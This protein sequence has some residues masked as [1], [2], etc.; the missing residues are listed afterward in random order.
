[1]NNE[2]VLPI[3]MREALKYEEET[4]GA[5]CTIINGAFTTGDLA[6]EAYCAGRAAPVTELEVKSAAVALFRFDTNWADGEPTPGQ[7]E[8][9]W[10]QQTPDMREQYERK[11]RL[12]LETA[13]KA[14]DK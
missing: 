9:W 2:T 5:D 13:R 12:V 4:E 7:V 8:Q 6:I 1:M 10:N 3:A 14:V 11:A